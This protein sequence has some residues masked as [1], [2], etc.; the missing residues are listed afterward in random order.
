MQSSTAEFFLKIFTFP[1]SEQN[2]RLAGNFQLESR[3]PTHSHISANVIGPDV[4][5]DGFVRRKWQFDKK[6]LAEYRFFC[7]N[8]SRFS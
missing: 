2:I 1:V 3:A 5:I 7:Q 4:G 6:N 8:E